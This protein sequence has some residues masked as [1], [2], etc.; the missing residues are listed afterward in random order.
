MELV[1]KNII[2]IICGVVALAAVA[3]AFVIVPGR[4]EQLQANVNTSKSAHDALNTLLT[5]PRKLPV[6]NPDNPEEKTL[7]AFPSDA[8]LKQ[9]EALTKKVEDESKAIFKAA[10]EM[11]KHTL[12][13]EGTLPAPFA[14]QQFAFRRG[15]TAALP[16]LLPPAQP[17][18]PP[19]GGAMKSYFAKDLQAGMPP[20]P[21]ELR[22]A[23]KRWQ[24][25]RS[26]KA[27]LHVAEH[28][29]ERPAGAGGDRRAHAQASA[30][31][32][33]QD[34][35]DRQGLHQPQYV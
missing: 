7:D 14:P 4:K 8:V 15:Y 19:S 31:D 29:G 27:G 26:R 32:A 34:R 10:V 20:T 24:E 1:K 33:R 25:D 17:N 2:S 18:Q 11:N 9:G 23:G 28:A 12:L 22:F 6:V 21:D 5:K 16:P 35:R 13:V 30:G 3:V